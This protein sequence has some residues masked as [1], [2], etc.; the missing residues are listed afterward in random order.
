MLSLIVN[1]PSLLKTM[2]QGID[3]PDKLQSYPHN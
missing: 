1:I 3:S 2:E